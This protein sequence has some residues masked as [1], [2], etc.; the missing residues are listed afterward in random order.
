MLPYIAPYLRGLWGPFRL[1]ESHLSLICLGA[2]L[3]ALLSFF[4]L[5]RLWRFMPRDQ[6][7]PFVKSSEEALGK[8]TGAGLLLVGVFLLCL[9]LVLP[10]VWQLW[11][12][13]AC[14]FAC[15]LCGFLDDASQGGW[16][17]LKKGLWDAV[18]A[19][20]AALI[21]CRGTD[22]VIWLPLV[23]GSLSGGGFLLSAWLYVPLAAALLWLSINVVNCSDGVDAM[24]GSLALLGLCALGA[25]L[26]GVVGHVGLAKYLL[27]PHNPEGANWAIMIF[28]AA[29]ALA[30]YVWHNANPSAVLM[31]DAGSRFLGLLIGLGVLACGNPFLYLAVAPILLVDGGIGLIKLSLLRSLKKLGYDVRPPLRNLVNQPGQASFATDEE[32]KKQLLIVRVIHAFR[33]PV[34]DHC[35]KNL[36]WSIP[37]VVIRFMLLQALLMPLILILILKLR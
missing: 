14:L 36:G 37:Q 10:F 11:A 25:V 9:L 13:A 18:I 27:L 16:S 23:K 22:T 6:G 28:C 33:C 24:A 8:P 1:F 7:K 12:L 3:A 17:E 29:G 30:G 15:M 34:H 35:R 2:T 21:M 5:P 4:L 31:G 20:L 32:A 19:V 26:Y